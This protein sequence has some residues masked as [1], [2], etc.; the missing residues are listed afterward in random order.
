MTRGWY[1][2]GVSK[3]HNRYHATV[4]RIS[5]Q[6]KPKWEKRQPLKWIAEQVGQLK[7]LLVISSKLKHRTIEHVQRLKLVASDFFQ[8]I[9]LKPHK[10]LKQIHET[11]INFY[12]SCIKIPEQ[13]YYGVDHG[14]KVSL[15]QLDQTMHW[16]ILAPHHQHNNS[17]EQK[18]LCATHLSII[19]I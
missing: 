7:L 4:R 14:A 2:I 6:S 17:Q 10:V 15:S 11:T 5:H 16:E 1:V 18:C 13:V 12:N 8:L 9:C 3:H 19:I